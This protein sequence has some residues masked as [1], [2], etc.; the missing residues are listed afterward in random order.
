MPSLQTYYSCSS[1]GLWRSII[2]FWSNSYQR[3]FSWSLI[4][5]DIFE[6][7]SRTTTWEVSRLARNVHLEVLKKSCFSERLEIQ[8]VCAPASDWWRYFDFCS[9]L[10]HWTSNVPLRVLKDCCVFLE[11]FEIQDGQPDLLIGRNIFD[12]MLSHQTFQKCLGDPMSFSKGENLSS[13]LL[14]HRINYNFIYI[15]VIIWRGFS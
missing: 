1:R 3:W 4:G 5:R 15:H 13:V 10:L 8:P 7:L 14:S 12:C 9:K 2:C 6:F 11:W